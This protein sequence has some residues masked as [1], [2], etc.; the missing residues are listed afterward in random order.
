MWKRAVAKAHA[1]ARV[2][3]VGRYTM[4]NPLTHPT[5]FLWCL[6]RYALAWE[7]VRVMLKVVIDRVVIRHPRDAECA[8]VKFEAPKQYTGA[9]H[10]LVVSAL[11]STALRRVLG[12]S[13]DAR[14][15]YY[16]RGVEHGGMDGDTRDMLEFMNWVFLGYLVQD[17]VHM[18]RAYP[19]LGKLDMVAHH[20]VFTVASVVHGVSQT[21][22]LPFTWLLLGELSTPLLTVRWS[23]Q[24]GAYATKSDWV[25]KVAKALGYKGDAVATHKNAGKQLEFFN[26]VC[27]MITFFSVR[28][29][30]YSIGYSH[31]LYVR[32][33]GLIDAVPRSVA[34]P[35]NAL[36]GCGAGLNAYWFSIMI[37]KAMQGPPPPEAAG[38]VSPARDAATE[39]SRKKKSS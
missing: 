38:D 30:A 5:V 37:R 17:T 9:I 24:S 4:P 7:C 22:M 28:I 14:D 3:Y 31:M 8:R 10:A 33:T 18:V 29:V 19:R 6:S 32:Y 36:V 16:G 12:G 11:A 27:L 1:H 15:W 23:I 25:I 39:N 2:A 26:G 21:M 34:W 20:V 13:S 35:L